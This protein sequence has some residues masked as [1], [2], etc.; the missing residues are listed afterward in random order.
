[1]HILYNCEY[2]PTDRQEKVKYN[3]KITIDQSKRE[4]NKP[5]QTIGF[6]HEAERILFCK[7]VMNIYTS[8]DLI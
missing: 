4:E 5:L 6:W 3:K 8:I 1:M 7:K 2:L